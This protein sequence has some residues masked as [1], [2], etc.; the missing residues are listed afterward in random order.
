MGFHESKDIYHRVG[1]VMLPAH[2]MIF[3]KCSDK[4]INRTKKKF[5]FS[6]PSFAHTIIQAE[7]K[8]TLVISVMT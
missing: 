4:M 7:R 1:Q 8:K 2:E 6:I 5:K 3:Q